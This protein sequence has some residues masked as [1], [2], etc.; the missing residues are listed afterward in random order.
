MGRIISTGLCSKRPGR[1]IA[2]SPS[3]LDT[4]GLIRSGGR[5]VYSHGRTGI[6]CYSL[7]PYLFLVSPCLYLFG[8]SAGVPQLHSIGPT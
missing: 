5:H 7:S 6:K 3:E 2:M 8:R 4:G 1:K